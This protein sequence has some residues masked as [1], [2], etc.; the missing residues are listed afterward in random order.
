MDVMQHI[1]K[2]YRDQ[3]MVDLL[4]TYWCISKMGKNMR[5]V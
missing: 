4:M 5:Y 1:L 2:P 3:F